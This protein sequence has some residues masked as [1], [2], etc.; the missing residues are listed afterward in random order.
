VKFNCTP[1]SLVYVKSILIVDDSPLIRRS[2]RTVFEQQPNWAV[3][4]EAE[5]GYEGIE[6][7]KILQ[8]DLIVIDLAMPRLNGI[9]AGRMLKKL[10]PATQIVMFT[11]FTNPSFRKAALAAGLDAFVGKSE[12]ATSLVRSMQRL[13]SSELPTRSASAA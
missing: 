8:P 2:L 7:A 11:A 5:D 4:G 6:K 12:G 10:V 9:S 3:C 1:L 13:L